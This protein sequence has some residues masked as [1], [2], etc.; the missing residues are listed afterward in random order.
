MNVTGRPETAHQADAPQ[1]H[2]DPRCPLLAYHNVLGADYVA[3]LLDHVMV[4]QSDFRT[5]L[6][7]NRETGEVG[8]DPVQRDAVYLTDLGA[9]AGP[10]KSLV[11]AVAAP[12]LRALRVSEAK[13]EP[14]E[15][16]ITA[17]RD[18]GHIG[19]HI[20]TFERP[21]RVRILSCVYYFAAAPRRFGGGEL[22]LYGLP[23]GPAVEQKQPAAFVDIEPRTDTLVVFPSWIRHQVMPVRVPSGAWLDSRFTINCWM[24]RAQ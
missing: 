10:I 15:F 20:D 14:R 16:T 19:E 2:A 21:D 12:A 6:M 7:R 18:G 4:R 13:V 1:P 17:Y 23:K 11:S 24:H 22:R 8:A 5:G 9:F 3:G